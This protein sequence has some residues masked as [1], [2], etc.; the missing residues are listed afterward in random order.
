MQSRHSSRL[1]KSDGLRMGC[2][3][4]DDVLHVGDMPAAAARRANAAV[5]ERL[6][7]SAKVRDTR[8]PDGVDNR[9]NIG[10][11]A[12][13]IGDL[14]RAASGGSIA[15]VAWIAQPSALGFAGSKR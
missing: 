11:E 12:I 14:N 4:V 13:S 15:R 7:D 3:S 1:L 5:V 8:C 6:R 10:S 2:R 9:Q